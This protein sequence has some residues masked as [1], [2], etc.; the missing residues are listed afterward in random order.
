M[1]IVQIITMDDSWSRVMQFWHSDAVLR[2]A[3]GYEGIT[4]YGRSSICASATSTWG[5]Q[6]VMSMAR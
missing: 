3:L 1:Y 2:A 4:H 5:S 6:K